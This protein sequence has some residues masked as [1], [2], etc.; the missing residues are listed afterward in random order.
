ME[1]QNGVVYWVVN[2]PRRLGAYYLSDNGVLAPIIEAVPYCSN[3]LV[4]CE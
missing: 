4:R 3:I 2:I 1:I